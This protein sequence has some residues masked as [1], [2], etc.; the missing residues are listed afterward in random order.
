MRPIIRNSLLIV[1]AAF[2]V[3]AAYDSI[4]FIPEGEEGVV[5]E[6]WKGE[7]IRTVGSGWHIKW[8]FIQE[9][10]YPYYIQLPSNYQDFIKD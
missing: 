4:F 1:S 7:I 2:L 3:A 8:P 5:T 9:A 10:S 6:V